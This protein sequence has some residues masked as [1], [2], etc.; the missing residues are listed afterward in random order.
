MSF[1]RRGEGA[2]REEQWKVR[3]ISGYHSCSKER[4]EGMGRK[5]RVRNGRG[6]WREERCW[7]HGWQRDVEELKRRSTGGQGPWERQSKEGDKGQGR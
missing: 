3:G 1:A 4:T 2:G 6:M 7:G 5:L